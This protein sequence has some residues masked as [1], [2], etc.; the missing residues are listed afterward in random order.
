[1]NFLTIEKTL[2]E[3]EDSRQEVLDQPCFTP[4]QDRE[5]LESLAQIDTAIVEYVAMEVQKADNIVL[6]LRSCEYHEK[7]LQREIELLQHRREAIQQRQKQLKELVLSVMQIRDKKQFK[8]ASHTLRRQGNGGQQP[9][10]VVQPELVPSHFQRVT[11]TLNRE[12]W[13]RAVGVLSEHD[14]NI[15]CA[16]EYHEPDLTAI[17]EAL[18]LGRGVPGCVLKE[19]GEHLRMT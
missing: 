12:H 14:F 2:E 17:R 19:R 10:D 16:R 9:V 13:G 3:L 1:M 15:E 6:Y 4:E 5:R 7:A 8:G 18:E 11:V